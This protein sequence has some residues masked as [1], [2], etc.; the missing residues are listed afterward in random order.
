MRNKTGNMF[1]FIDTE[2]GGLIPAKHSLLS[3]AFVIW[4]INVGIIDSTEFFIKSK[5][6]VVTEKAKEINGFNR[7]AHNMKAKDQKSTI[8]EMIEFLYKHFDKNV[9]IPIIGHNVQFDV[10]F[11]KVFF[12]KNGRSFNQ[13]FSHRIIDTYSVFKTLEISHKIDGSI[14][15]SADA[16]KYF[17]IKVENRHSA[18]GDCEATVKLYECLLKKLSC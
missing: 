5:R 8:N 4:D 6:Y 17:Q 12:E 1:L 13:Y 18:L 15:S 7:D 11:L 9:A 10:S 3:V 2:T 14:D 16:F